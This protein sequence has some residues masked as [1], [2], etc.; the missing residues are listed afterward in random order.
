MHIFETFKKR[1]DESDALSTTTISEIGKL[2][3]YFNIKL[4]KDYILFIT[5][6][7]NLYTPEI[8]D[9]IV[10]KDL[11]MFDVQEF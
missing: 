4:P 7:G 11:A 5:E 9:N 10:N 8:L 6:Y 1:F 3:T 2:E